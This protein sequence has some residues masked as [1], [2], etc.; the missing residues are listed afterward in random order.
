MRMRKHW[1]RILAGLGSVLIPLVAVGWVTNRNVSRTLASRCESRVMV[2]NF[3]RHNGPTTTPVAGR[4][5]IVVNDR[6]GGK[7]SRT[8]TGTAVRDPPYPARLRVRIDECATDTPCSSRTTAST[9]SCNVTIAGYNATGARFSETLVSVDE[10]VGG[11]L[12]DTVISRVD[13]VSVAGC[14]N[15]S[16]NVGRL[17]VWTS[18]VV[19]LP[20]PTTSHTVSRNSATYPDMLVSASLWDV[21]ASNLNLL[22]DRVA[23]QGLALTGDYDSGAYDLTR[24]TIN[25]DDADVDTGDILR[26]C[27]KQ[28]NDG[29]PTGLEPNP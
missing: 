24:D 13:T 21:S 27:V 25:I 3:F 23:S 15:N 4:N 5:G 8:V 22:Q 17:A 11:D 9:L 19:S 6:F 14:V 10:D 28:P 18:T 16:T 26:I 20:M 29:A 7:A 2:D 12:T 1:K